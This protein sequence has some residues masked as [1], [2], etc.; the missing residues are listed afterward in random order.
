ML[1]SVSDVHGMAPG[2]GLPLMPSQRT[3]HGAGASAPPPRGCL[4]YP[5]AQAAYW[6]TSWNAEEG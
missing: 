3:E 6:D 4:L 5:E 1:S 2:T